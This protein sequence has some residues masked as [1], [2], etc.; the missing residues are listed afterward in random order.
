[1]VSV[2]QK[3]SLAHFS[4]FSWHFGVC[5]LQ[6]VCFHVL[7]ARAFPMVVVVL[8]L[9]LPGYLISVLIS[10]SAATRSGAIS[11]FGGSV[12]VMTVRDA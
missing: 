12:I 4:I 10:L 7:D 8:L 5:L 1:M 3:N 9:S 2:F 11:G 6:L